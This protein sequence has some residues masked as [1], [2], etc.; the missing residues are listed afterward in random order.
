MSDKNRPYT[1]KELRV[2]QKKYNMSEANVRNITYMPIDVQNW[3]INSAKKQKLYSN[4]PTGDIETT[5]RPVNVHVFGDAE[6]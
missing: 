5:L 4:E 2:F 3:F 6:N 1:E